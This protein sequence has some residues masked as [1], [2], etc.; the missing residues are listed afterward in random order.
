MRT[1]L[2]GVSFP[3]DDEL[4]DEAGTEVHDESLDFFIVSMMR[5]IKK[6]RSSYKSISQLDLDVGCHHHR[7]Q[8]EWAKVED[9]SIEQKQARIWIYCNSGHHSQRT[10]SSQKGKQSHDVSKLEA[11]TNAK[12]NNALSAES[13]G[14]WVYAIARKQSESDILGY[15]TILATWR[16]IIPDTPPHCHALGG[17]WR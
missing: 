14:R 9:A 1:N 8:Y 7:S 12:T 13:F 17:N 10:H 2:E 6:L 16:Q 15:P 4:Y 11:L 3:W 5:H